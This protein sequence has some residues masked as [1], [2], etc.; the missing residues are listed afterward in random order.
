MG[1]DEV[2]ET[3]G[4]NAFADVDIIRQLLVQDTLVDITVVGHAMNMVYKGPI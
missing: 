4:V 1:S 3:S 2:S